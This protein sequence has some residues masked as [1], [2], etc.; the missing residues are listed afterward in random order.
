MTLR[1]GL[2]LTALLSLTM[3]TSALA[4][5]GSIWPSPIWRLTN[6]QNSVEPETDRVRVPSNPLPEVLQE[7]GDSVVV[8]RDPY[9]GNGQTCADDAVSCDE[10]APCYAPQ[11]ES[12]P[13]WFGSIGWVFMTR[14]KE[15]HTHFSYDDIDESTQLLDTR[16]TEMD[17]SSGVDM[18]LGHYFNC[19]AN[20]IEAIYWGVY[21]ENEQTRI[22]GAPGPL[23]GNLNGIFNFDQLDYNGAPANTFVD[24]ALVH[25]LRREWEFHNIEL[26]LLGVTGNGGFYR[27]CNSRWLYSWVTGVRYFRFDEYLEFAADT[28]DTVFNGDPNEIGYNI[29]IENHLLGYQVGGRGD[30][31]VCDK[32]SIYGASKIGIY[33][34]HIRHQ[35]RIG[36]SAGDAVVNNGPNAG[37]AFNVSGHKDDFAMLA[38]LDLGLDYRINCCWNAQVGYRAIAVSGVALPVHQIPPDLRG[39]DDNEFIASTNSLILHGAYVSL[40]Y[41][42]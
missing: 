35:S 9:L 24:A 25:R 8:G 27:S 20:A 12:G 34:N 10:G 1:N 18:R 2:C 42:Y 4:Q 13:C 17:W 26:N 32:L 36:G 5:E 15:E 11:V 6:L 33:N 39:V 3:S 23:G 41:C 37:R 29:D 22:L 30:Y 40:A 28:V 38:E 14:D 16:D 19:G 31:C 7:A 21:A